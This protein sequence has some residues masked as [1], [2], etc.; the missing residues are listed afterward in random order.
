MAD[1]IGVSQQSPTNE[2]GVLGYK[3][4]MRTLQLARLAWNQYRKI[5]LWLSRSQRISDSRGSTN[6][7]D[8]ESL[9]S[10]PRPDAMDNAMHNS[11]STRRSLVLFCIAFFAYGLMFTPGLYNKNAT[12]RI[13]LSISLADRG[14]L[15]ID[16]FAPLTGDRATL[17]DHFASDKAPGMSFLALPAVAVAVRI[18]RLLDPDTRWLRPAGQAGLT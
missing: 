17:G 6:P 10:G 14:S 9:R 11:K 15:Y 12:S 8:R 5:R 2:T 13:G 16:D 7:A 1:V 18:V 4:Q 3:A